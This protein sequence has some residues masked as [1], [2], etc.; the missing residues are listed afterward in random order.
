MAINITGVRSKDV[1]GVRRRN[2]GNYVGPTSY[3]NPTGEVITAASLGLAVIEEFD[4]PQVASTA[5]GGAIRLLTIFYA[6][7]GTSVTVR[8]WTDL[9]TEVVNAI[10]LSTYSVRFEAVGR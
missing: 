4:V 9:V 6:T 5:A 7:D 8:W 10:D 3:V 2:I 1:A